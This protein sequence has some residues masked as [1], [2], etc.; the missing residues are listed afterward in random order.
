[1]SLFV[2]ICEVADYAVDK[3]LACLKG[4]R[5]RGFIP[6]LDFQFRKINAAGIDTRRSACFKSLEI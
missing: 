4:K 2:G 3:R 6:S 1:M 5:R